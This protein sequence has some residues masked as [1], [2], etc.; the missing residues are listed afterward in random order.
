MNLNRLMR[1]GAALCTAAWLAVPLQAFAV[2]CQ[3]PADRPTIQAA[4]D[5]PSCTDIV[6]GNQIY[7]ESV[8]IARSLLM[9]GP[10]GGSAVIRGAVSVTGASVLAMLADFGIEDGCPGPGLAADQSAEIQAEE[11]TVMSS[12]Q[13]ACGGGDTFFSNGFE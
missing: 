3:V 10:D 9:F 1:A 6:L 8:A 12:G 4:V 11:V 2:T 7:A 13:F 5:D